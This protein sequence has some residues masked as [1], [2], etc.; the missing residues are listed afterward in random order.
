LKVQISFE[1]QV[2]FHPEKVVAISYSNEIEWA[3]TSLSARVS[4]HSNHLPGQQHPESSAAR[5]RAN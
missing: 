3:D 2:C 1:M 5:R 4:N